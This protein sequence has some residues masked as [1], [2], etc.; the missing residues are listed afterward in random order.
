MKTKSWVANMIQMWKPDLVIFEDIQLQ[1][2][3]RGEE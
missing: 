2:N 3:E 1:K